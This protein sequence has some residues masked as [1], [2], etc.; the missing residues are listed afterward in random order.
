MIEFNDTSKLFGKWTIIVNTPFGKEDYILNIDGI[1]SVK[2]SNQNNCLIGSIHHEKGSVSFDDA[3]FENNTFHC[4]VQTEFP[5][6]ST[7]SITAEL[8]QDNQISGMLEIDQYLVTSF[9]GV[10]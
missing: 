7:I 1:E 4:S 5:I 10:K 2:D 8:T 3:S 9:V 6:K